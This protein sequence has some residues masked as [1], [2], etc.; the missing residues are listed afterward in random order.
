MTKVVQE[1]G[2]HTILQ[3]PQ[4]GTTEGMDKDPQQQM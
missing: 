2:G 4:G 3:Y 1:K